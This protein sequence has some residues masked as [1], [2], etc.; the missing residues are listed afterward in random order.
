MREGLKNSE[1]DL[2]P[3]PQ[4]LYVVG[5]LQGAFKSK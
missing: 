1:E 4:G 3:T 5:Y 2:A